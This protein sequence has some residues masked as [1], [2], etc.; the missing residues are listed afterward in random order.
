VVCWVLRFRY[1]MVQCRTRHV[2]VLQVLL[3]ISLAGRCVRCMLAERSCLTE[4]PGSMSSAGC[5]SCTLST[6][7]D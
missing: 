4:L 1:D 3:V 2:H 5:A 7:V 6:L